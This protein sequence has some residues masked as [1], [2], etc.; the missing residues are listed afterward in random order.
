M[1]TGGDEELDF[2]SKTLLSFMKCFLNHIRV[3]FSF[4]SEINVYSS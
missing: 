3:H 1:E 4:L 2:P